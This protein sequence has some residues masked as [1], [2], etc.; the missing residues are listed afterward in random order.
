MTEPFDEHNDITQA[1]EYALHLMD[2]PARHAF[3]VRLH[4][5]VDLRELLHSWDAD[6]IAL[7]HEF[8]PVTPPAGL[9]TRIET[10]LF[11]A[12][13]TAS[14]W[15]W[16][17]WGAGTLAA[18]S[19]AGM[20]VFGLPSNTSPAVIA[21]IAA[22]DQSLRISVR[23]DSAA[24]VLLTTRLEGQ[25]RPERSLELWLIT[26]PD[27][28]P[29]SLGVLTAQASTQFSVSTYNATQLSG[30]TLAISD[31]P[32]G[33]SPTGLPTGAVLATGTVLDLDA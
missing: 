23:W 29:V 15:V 11:G 28:A 30:A 22:Q 18:L 33:G 2:A 27:T 9:K 17:R 1:G 10:A 3:E 14:P 24:R 26:G 13:K 19:V 6:L 31:E 4:D 8:A 25:A 21:E 16:L 5:D 32:L 12:Q 7:A 20:F